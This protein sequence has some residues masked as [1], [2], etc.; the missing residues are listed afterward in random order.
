MQN[1]TKQLCPFLTRKPFKRKS[2]FKNSYQTRKLK[3]KIFLF[4]TEFYYNTE[5]KKFFLNVG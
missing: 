5:M 4:K 2:F 1:K 3:N